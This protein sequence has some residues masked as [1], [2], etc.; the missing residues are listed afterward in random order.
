MQVKNM[1]LQ[2]RVIAS[3]VSVHLGGSHQTHGDIDVM[4]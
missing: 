2:S 3:A 1:H 4:D